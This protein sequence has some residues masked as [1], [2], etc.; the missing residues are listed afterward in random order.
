MATEKS[1]TEGKLP[2]QP[3]NAAQVGFYM[4]TF[5]NFV[6]KHNLGGTIDLQNLNLR[7]NKDEEGKELT[8]EKQRKGHIEQSR[9]AR[10]YFFNEQKKKR[11]EERMSQLSPEEKEELQTVS[12]NDLVTW[13]NRT[14]IDEERKKTVKT[15]PGCF[16]KARA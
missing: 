14:K 13:F 16:Y 3:G 2:V 10:N 12:D 7:D 15:I 5:G 6:K 1:S 8:I 11:L 4:Q 9:Q